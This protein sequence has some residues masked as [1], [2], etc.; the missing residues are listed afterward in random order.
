M[1]KLNEERN[2]TM[3]YNRTEDTTLRRSALPLVCGILGSLCFA[4]SDWL[5]M[6]GD[7][8]HGGNLF[9]LTQGIVEIAPWKNALA[10]VLAFPGTVLDGIALFSLGRN[11]R[12]AN[13]RRRWRTLVSFGLT[14]WMALHLF[15]IMILFLFRWLNLNG[16]A[17]AALPACEALYAHMAFLV[18]LC[19]V[20]MVPPFLYWFYLQ[21]TGKTVYHRCMAFTNMLLF[22]AV[23]SVVKL[24]LPESAFRLGFTNA[25]MNESMLIWFSILLIWAF[26]QKRGEKNK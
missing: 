4:L 13:A 17:Q 26:R 9:W 7:P 6:Y 18:P 10:M 21:F 11:I 8:S 5:M 22:Y 16:F 19:M 20:L 14:P 25:L 1:K 12:E 3:D 23:L 2:K 24:M 15:Y